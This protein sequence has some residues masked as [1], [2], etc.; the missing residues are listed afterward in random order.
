M[1]YHKKQKQIEGV[2]VKAM[3]FNANFNNSSVNS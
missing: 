3:V 2:R 1:K